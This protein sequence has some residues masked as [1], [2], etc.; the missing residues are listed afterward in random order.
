MMFIAAFG[1]NAFLAAGFLLGY[2]GDN[3]LTD[4]MC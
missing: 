3:K 2:C 1:Y 4:G